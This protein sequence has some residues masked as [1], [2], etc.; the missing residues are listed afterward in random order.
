MPRI[1]L[2]ATVCLLATACGQ[3][4][5]V[6]RLNSAPTVSIVAPQPDEL[7]RQG[8]GDIALIAE[9][10]DSHTPAEELTVSWVVDGGDAIAAAVDGDGIAIASL[11]PDGMSTGTHEAVVTVVDEDG[12]Q[13]V[14]AVRFLV[15][16]PFGA[17]TVEITAPDDGSSYL[18]QQSVTFRGQAEDATTPAGELSFHW[19]SDLD[20]DLSGAVTAGGES[21]L[22]A[23]GLSAGTHLVTLTVTDADGEVGADFINVTLSDNDVIAQPGDLVFSEFMVNPQVVEDEVGEWV[24]L[25]NTS[26]SAIDVAGYSF[27]DDDY[28]NFVLEGPLVV[29]PNDYIVLCADTNPATNGGVPCDGWFLRDPLGDGLALANSPDELVLSRPDGTQIDWV[30]YEPSWFQAGAASG[31]S[32]DQLEGGSNDYAEAWCVQTTIMTSGGEPGTPGVE[33][34]VCPTE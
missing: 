24:E 11:S 7:F 30:H 14:A 16:G 28:D 21:L 6:S 33:N 4:V 17:P 8:E 1:A 20:G 15:G 3:P 25:Y 31:V 9:V 5:G 32:P 26:G 10:F 22:L 13:G 29:G 23:E 2:I 34:D 12:S 18:V 27:H 19:A